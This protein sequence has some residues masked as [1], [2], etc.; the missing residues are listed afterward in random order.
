MKDFENSLSILVAVNTL[1][2]YEKL[3]SRSIICVF[4]ENLSKIIASA[5]APARSTHSGTFVPQA[6]ERAFLNPQN[7]RSTV[8]KLSVPRSL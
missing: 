4:C 8:S 7:V 2:S 6:M 3:F 5:L 1:L